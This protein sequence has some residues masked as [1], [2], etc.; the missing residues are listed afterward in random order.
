[1]KI[2]FYEKTQN[3][4]YDAWAEEAYKR[5]R[6]PVL[7]EDI[8]Q[9]LESI[10]ARK[11]VRT[12]SEYAEELRWLCQL[13]FLLHYVWS[14]AQRDNAGM[15]NLVQDYQTIWADVFPLSK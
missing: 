6:I 4:G 2:Y 10:F 11:E 12:P 13:E 3:K 7:P 1:M 15:R 5:E 8:A 14:A 9:R